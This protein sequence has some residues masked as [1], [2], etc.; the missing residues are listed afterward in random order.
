MGK[1]YIKATYNDNGQK[2]CTNCK[3][4]KNFSEFHKRSSSPDGIVTYCKVCVKEIDTKRN[5]HKLL[6]PKKLVDDLIHCRRCEKYL[7]IEEFPKRNGNSKYSRT[8]CIPCDKEIGHRFNLKRFGLTAEQ[9]VDMEKSQ[10]GVCAICKQKDPIKR[11]SVDH[12]HSCCPGEK[13]CGKCN[14]GL[15]CSKCNKTLGM[16]SDD[17]KILQDMINYLQK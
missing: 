16:V 5:E 9:Y 14:R 3:V 17:I 10:N 12:D 2:L 13:T 6:K 7:A 4:F 1:Q 11:L 15:L 8:Y